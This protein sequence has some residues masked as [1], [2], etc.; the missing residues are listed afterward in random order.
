MSHEELSPEAQA[1]MQ[2]LADHNHKDQGRL[3]QAMKDL[4]TQGLRPERLL[5]PSA[6]YTEA[7]KRGIDRIF[8]LE[9]VLNLG[10][11]EWYVAPSTLFTQSKNVMV[12]S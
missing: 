3:I 4:G 5:L 1:V 12:G 10:E 6:A 2:F 8:G 11:D 7:Q 9:I